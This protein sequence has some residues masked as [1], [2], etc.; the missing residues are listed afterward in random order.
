MRSPHRPMASL[1]VD[2]LPTFV[3]LT[4]VE[5]ITMSLAASEHPIIASY[6]CPVVGL[7]LCGTG[8]YGVFKPDEGQSSP[9]P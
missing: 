7:A 8:L 1:T 9:L 2:P 4:T 5:H 3:H 6:V